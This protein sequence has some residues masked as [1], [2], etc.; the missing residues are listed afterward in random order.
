MA[1]R[2]VPSAR[3]S[4]YP[5]KDRAGVS[6]AMPCFSNVTECFY[7]A[8]GTKPAC[9]PANIVHPRTILGAPSGPLLDSR[10]HP[11]HLQGWGYQKET[12]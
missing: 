4:S 7:F 8:T 2:G 1:K 3:A 6:D 9:T 5:V 11:R 10:F 12:S